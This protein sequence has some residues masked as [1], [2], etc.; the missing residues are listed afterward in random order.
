MDLSKKRVLVVDDRPGMLSSLRH[1]LT[2]CGISSAHTVRT[3]HDAVQRLRNM[4]YDIV[5]ADFDLGV[6]PDGQQLLEHCRCEALLAPTAVF[7]MITAERSYDRVMSAA[8]FA[9][10]DYLVKPFTED[11]LR[12]RLV[13]ALERRQVL[14]PVFALG[15]QQQHDEVVRACDRLT[16][17]AP[18]H[19]MELARIK[20]EALLAAGRYPEALALFDQMLSLRP[21]PWARL[22]RARAQ[23]AMGEVEAARIA[24]TELL[25]DAP[26]YLAAYDALVQLHQRTANDADAKAVL[27]MA[28]EVSP[29][30]VHRHKIVGEIAL[31]TKDLEVA[32]AALG[33]VV[34]KNRNG[35]V[36]S[37]DDHLKLA[38][39]LLERNKFAQALETLAETKRSFGEVGAVRACAAAIECQVYSKAG[40]PRESRKALDEALAAGQGGDRHLPAET[41]LA[42]ARACFENKRE[43]EGTA[44]AKQVVSNN[45]DDAGLLAQVRQMFEQLDRAEQGETLIERC[46]KDAVA[47]NNEGVGRAKQ[48]DL[49]GAIELLEEAARTMPDNAHIVMNAAHALI[50]HMQ[51]HGLQD[52]KRSRVESYIARIRERQPRHPKYLQVVGLYAA[53]LDSNGQAAA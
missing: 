46:V 48:G 49:E 18:R 30:A 23:E 17:E 7:V 50:A 36:R 2:A 15:A 24:L 52:D 44:L 22:G 20:G 37:A 39:V 38:R 28:L 12:L 19:A 4:R 29:N 6:G 53:L 14:A 31:R 10:D 42:L 25:A 1:A 32:E 9:P 11:T 26:E 13:R 8:E 34:R 45:H 47:I 3:A 16:V 51:V 40:N 21:I 41:A 27:R 43:H 5:L 35:F 33:T